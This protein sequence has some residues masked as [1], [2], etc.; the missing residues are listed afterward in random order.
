MTDNQRL[1]NYFALVAIVPAILSIIAYEF[2][3]YCGVF[4]LPETWRRNFLYGL[5]MLIPMALMT[6]LF[7]SFFSC[8]LSKRINKIAEAM[9]KVAQGDFS[10]EVESEKL[11]PFRDIAINFNKMTKEL[12]SVETLRKDFINDFSHE[13]KTPI[14]SINGFAKLLLETDVSEEDR[15]AYLEIIA[16]ES[17][18]LAT[19][20]GNTMML[21]KLENQT[22]LPE[23]EDYRL[24]KQIRQNIILLSNAWEE[25]KIQ[26]DVDLEEIT[27]H[28]NADLMSHVWMNLLNNAIKFTIEALLRRAKIYAEKKIEIGSVTLS[29]ASYTVQRKKEGGQIEQVQLPK[30]EFE[31]LY[32]LL[33]YPNQIFTKEQLLEEIWG[34][35]T[36]SD[37][38]TIKTHISRIRNRF[39]QWQEFSVVTIRGLGYKAEY[40]S[41]FPSDSMVEYSHYGKN[42]G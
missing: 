27:Y 21:S 2:I 13:F 42:E 41:S 34:Y 37:D 14:S 18:R 17:E 10:I 3:E 7:T 26:M 9:Q 4:V 35:D 25:K 38:T 29:E 24:D 22:I 6:E 28:G 30:K 15:R 16:E 20:A 40:N 1:P 36:D 11:K 32:K 33:S 12:R 23:A 19:L 8:I 39:A 31:L 5:G